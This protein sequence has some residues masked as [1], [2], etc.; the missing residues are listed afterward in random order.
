MNAL[1]ISQY[2]QITAGSY[3]YIG[4]QG[5]VHGTTTTVLNGFRKLKCGP[6]LGLFVSSELGGM[7][8][9]QPKAG[10]IAGYIT[11]CDEVNFKITHVLHSQGWINEVIENVDDLVKK[12]A[13][14]QANNEIVSI[15]I[16]RK[17]S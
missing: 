6:N 8:G 5:I 10:N 17:C 4:P 14:G 15:R 2:G 9:A 1:G 16:S 7:S 13:L 12:V 3:I 11:V